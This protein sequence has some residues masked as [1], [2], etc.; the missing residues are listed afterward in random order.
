MKNSSLEIVSIFTY[1]QYEKNKVRYWRLYGHY[2]FSVLKT[3]AACPL[4]SECIGHPNNWVHI[5]QQNT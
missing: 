3:A 2:S 5:L 1:I 4:R